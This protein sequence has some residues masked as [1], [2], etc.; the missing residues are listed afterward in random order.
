[1]ESPKNQ[2]LNDLVQQ[3]KK[4]FVY[5]V[6]GRSIHARLWSLDDVLVSNAQLT[7]LDV[8]IA[9]NIDDFCVPD[10]GIECGLSG[11]VIV[12]SQSNNSLLE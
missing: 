1:M 10:C 6:H 3:P 5:A 11:Q 7:T 12:L 9:E 2:W 4:T 8:Q